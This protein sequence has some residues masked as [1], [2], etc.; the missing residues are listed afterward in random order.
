MLFLLLQTYKQTTNLS[1]YFASCCSLNT[2][3]NVTQ[4]GF[5]LQESN[6]IYICPNS[7]IG[8]KMFINLFWHIT[9]PKQLHTNAKCAQCSYGISSLILLFIAKQI[10]QTPTKRTNNCKAHQLANNRFTAPTAAQYHNQASVKTL[11]TPGTGLSTFSC[12]SYLLLPLPSLTLLAGNIGFI[13]LH[14]RVTLNQYLI[15]SADITAKTQGSSL[16][17]VTQWKA[18]HS[19]IP[20]RVLR[21]S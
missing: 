11:G 5:D 21:L 20:V 8:K 7:Y 16:C 6:Y 4:L 14:G 15:S 2:S 13:L 1:K 17:V 12:Y 19:S 18:P 10:E 9:Q 3:I